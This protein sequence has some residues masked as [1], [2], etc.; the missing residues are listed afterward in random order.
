MNVVIPMAG[1]GSRLSALGAPKPLVEVAGKPLLAWSTRWLAGLPEARVTVIALEEHERD[2]GLVATVAAHMPGAGCLLI[3]EV[4]QGQLCTVLCAAE[5]LDTDAPL[6]IAPCDTM[7]EGPLPVPASLT[8]SGNADVR[9][10]VS[11]ASMPGDRWSFADCDA[12]WN[13]SRVTEKVRISE[14]AS[15]GLYYFAH[16]GR[17]L[18]DARRMVEGDE[19]VKGEFYVM[20]LYGRMLARGERI[21]A[22]PVHAMHDLGTPEALALFEQQLKNS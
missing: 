20:P 10:I 3:P 4:T 1:R 15:T 22:V 17:F 8:G 19:R 13:V 16:T 12:D 2:F 7:I 18:E 5:R 9:G 6:L 14:W 21:K 11:V